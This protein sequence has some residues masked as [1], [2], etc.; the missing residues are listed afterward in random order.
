MVRGEENG[1]INPVYAK[2]EIKILPPFWASTW[3][4]VFYVLVIV[5]GLFWS[6]Y[7]IISSARIKFKKE[8]QELEQLRR[9]ELDAMK[10]HFLRM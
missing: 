1:V 5:I 2:L 7:R 4:Y 8:Q 10:I 3:A 6:R 9:Q